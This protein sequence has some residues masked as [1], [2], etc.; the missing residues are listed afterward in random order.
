MPDTDKRFSLRLPE[1]L[2][3]QLVELAEEDMRS[4]HAEIIMLL[5]EAIA[6]RQKQKEG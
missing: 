6:A 4:I 3:A 5:K 1:E 2:H